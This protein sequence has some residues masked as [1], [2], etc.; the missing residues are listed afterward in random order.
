MLQSHCKVFDNIINSSYE[1]RSGFF[2]IWKQYMIDSF[3]HVLMMCFF[4]FIIRKRIVGDVLIPI[5]VQNRGL[6]N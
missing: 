4:N 1:G 6:H 3:R 2:Y 5:Q